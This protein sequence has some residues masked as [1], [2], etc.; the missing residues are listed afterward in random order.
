MTTINPYLN[1]MG[2][3][4]KAM[5]FYKSVFGG[6]FSILQRFRDIPGG[7]K[8]PDHDQEKIMNISLPL[9]K[10]NIL[11]A[12]DALESMGQVLNVGNNFHLSVNT[13]SEKEADRIFNALADHGQIKLAMN[14]AFWGAYFGMLTDKFGIQWMVSYDF[15]QQK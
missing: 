6:E 10:G 5:N 12:T 15:S 13:D 9:S 4:E 1:F 8:M 3:T 2:N 14:K 11:M 7:E